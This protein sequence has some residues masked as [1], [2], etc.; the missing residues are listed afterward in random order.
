MNVVL[1][2]RKDLAGLV[3][4]LV[5][6]AMDYFKIDDQMLKLTLMGGLGSLFGMGAL[7]TAIPGMNNGKIAVA[8]AQAAAAAAANPAPQ[9]VTIT[10]P[11]VSIE[12][13]ITP[14]S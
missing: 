11:N 13:K 5:L 10:A 1:E 3:I 4:I 2:M 14:Q 12:G 8:Q 7:Q 6:F 9:S